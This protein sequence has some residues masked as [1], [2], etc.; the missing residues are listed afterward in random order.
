MDPSKTFQV[1]KW[2]RIALSIG[3]LFLGA[4]IGWGADY[5]WTQIVT[6]ETAGKIVFAFGLLKTIYASFAP[7]SGV[8]TTPTDGYVVTQR[9]IQKLP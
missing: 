4:V 8:A 3:V 1:N 9:G 6:K 5:D 7:G 2:L